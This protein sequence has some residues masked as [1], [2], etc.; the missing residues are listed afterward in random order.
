[1]KNI[2]KIVVL[3]LLVLISSG[4]LSDP[5][6]PATGAVILTLSGDIEHTNN[7]DVAEFDRTMLEALEQGRIDTRNPWADG[8]NTYEGPTGVA[9]MDAVGA[10]GNVLTVTA[11]N[12]YA[13]EL[14][15]SDLEDYGV[16]FAT[17]MNGQQLRIRDRGPLFVIYPMSD[18]PALNSER[19]HNRSVWQVDSV[20]IE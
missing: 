11:L 18:Q 5:L 1:M 17:H 16:I 13:A 7:G 15:R 9:L 20:V 12:D 14:P 2:R 8:E 10:K 3:V 4:A 6:P 19:Y